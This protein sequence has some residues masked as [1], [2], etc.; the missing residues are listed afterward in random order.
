MRRFDAYTSVRSIQISNR[1]C[2]RR[3]CQVAHQTRRFNTHGAIRLNL[4]HISARTSSQR[5]IVYKLR[6]HFAHISKAQPDAAIASR[7]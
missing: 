7:L 4:P 1:I 2:Q 5:F 3:V 6:Q